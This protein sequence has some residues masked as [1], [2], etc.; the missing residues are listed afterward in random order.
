MSWGTVNALRYIARLSRGAARKLRWRG[1]KP[2]RGKPVGPK[3]VVGRGLKR[4]RPRG[5]TERTTLV[6]ALA[7]TALLLFAGWMALFG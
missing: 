5:W 3:L 2:K 6:V 4:R 7:I 1:L